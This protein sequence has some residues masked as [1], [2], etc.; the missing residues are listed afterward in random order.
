MWCVWIWNKNCFI[1]QN[2]DGI[3]DCSIET[4]GSD[5]KPSIHDTTIDNTGYNTNF[6]ALTASDENFV[7]LNFVAKIK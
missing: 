1:R 3:I 7:H 6:A 2:H 5:G 4:V